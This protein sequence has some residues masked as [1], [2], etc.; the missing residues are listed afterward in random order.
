M[1]TIP[2]TIAALDVPLADVAQQVA[3]DVLRKARA[4]TNSPSDALAYSLD[5]FLVTHPKAPV[6]A[7]PDY[8]G[9]ADWVAQQQKKNDDARRAR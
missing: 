3:C 2:H 9:F 7:D 6:S 4:A 8:P 1:T 5:L